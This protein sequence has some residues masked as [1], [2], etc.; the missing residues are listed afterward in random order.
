VF[1]VVDGKGFGLADLV[2]L[3]GVDKF[4]DHLYTREALMIL[5]CAWF[6]V[7]LSQPTPGP[8][9]IVNGTDADE[10][11]FPTVV[12][13]S[14]GCSGSLIAPNVV[15]TAG[16]CLDPAIAMPTTA[17][18]LGESGA[19][20]VATVPVVRCER[21][22]E[23][24]GIEQQPV[25]Q[26]LFDVGFCELAQSVNDVPPIPILFG[27]DLDELQVGTPLV[28]VGYGATSGG[29]DTPTVG[30][31]TKRFGNQTVEQVND[32][33]GDLWMIG[34]EAA[35][36]YGDSGGP[37]LM[38]LADGSWRLV[39]VASTIHPNG[40]GYCGY[41][42]IYELVYPAVEWLESESGV[43]LTPCHDVDGTWNPSELCDRLPTAPDA[44]GNAWA[45]AC[46]P[47]AESEPGATCGEPFGRG[48]TGTGTDGDPDTGEETI[49]GGQSSI[50]TTG[51]ATT[52]APPPPL[53]D[54]A[55]GTSLATAETTGGTDGGATDASGCGCTTTA[56]ANAYWLLALSIF[57]RRRI[58]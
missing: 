2:A 48:G 12:R 55:E 42:S 44:V 32:A 4:S 31:G 50:G 5:G 33:E 46:G 57:A 51:P 53:D 21:H 7:A 16:H 26:V 20:S 56:P 11:Q 1:R 6:L 47:H 49:S 15:L 14:S 28:I 58:R 36:C 29:N 54:D 41:G 52:T 17:V 24:Q 23:Y 40:G 13:L 22:P 39:A 10:C 9:P 34:P 38:Q 43:D 37:A 30:S 25:A 27:C 3:R 45:N 35:S 8:Q 19:A 18:Q